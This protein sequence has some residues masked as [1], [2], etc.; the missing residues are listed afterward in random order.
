MCWCHDPPPSRN[1]TVDQHSGHVPHPCRTFPSGWAL[2][3]VMWEPPLSGE[4]VPH[5][6]V[7]NPNIRS[8]PIKGEHGGVGQTPQMLLLCWQR[9]QSTSRHSPRSTTPESVRRPLDQEGQARTK[10]ERYPASECKLGTRGQRKQAGGRFCVMHYQGRPSQPLGVCHEG[11]AS[12]LVG[13]SS[14][15]H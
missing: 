8:A 2:C 6:P 11:R 14:C 4:R 1:R 13:I 9:R 3:Y 12:V 5:W 15:T 10:G 7:T